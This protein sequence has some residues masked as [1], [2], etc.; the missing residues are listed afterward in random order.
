MIL[1]AMISAAQDVARVRRGKNDALIAQLLPAM[2][3]AYQDVLH[4]A[5]ALLLAR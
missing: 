3:S 4:Y 5:P 2:L 1:P